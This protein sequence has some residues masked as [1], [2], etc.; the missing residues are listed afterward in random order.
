MYATAGDDCRFEAT[1]SIAT[2]WFS[3]KYPITDEKW[4][5]KVSCSEV[6]AAKADRLRSGQVQDERECGVQG[7][8]HAGPRAQEQE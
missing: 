8:K 3:P 2:P 1:R 6:C 5:E 4:A 7:K